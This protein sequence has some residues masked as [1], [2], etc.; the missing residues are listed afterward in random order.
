MNVETTLPNG[1]FTA[2]LTPLK[3]DLSVDY[4]ALIAH[5]NWLLDNGSDG[6]ALL[7]TTGE[8]NSFTMEERME[9][10]DKI[11]ESGISGNRLMAGT[12]CCAF[13]D[14]IRLTKFAVERGIGGILMLPPFYYKQ[15]NDK[16]LAKYFDL[17]ING[18]KDERLKIYLY[19]FPKMAGVGFSTPLIKHLVKE[20]P[21]KVVGMKD[22]TGDFEHMKEIINEFPGFKLYAGTEKYLLDILKIGGAGCISA[23]A[24]V[25]L[26]LTAKV[27]KTWK[28]GK[29]AAE[30][31][32]YLTQ[33]RMTF[34]GLPFT[35]ALKSLLGHLNY[36]DA[37]KH[38]RPPNTIV[39]VAEI[40]KLKEKHQALNFDF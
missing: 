22:S 29:N 11:I 37:W 32:S 2:N 3:E 33:V 16:G 38:V 17:I 27:Y 7:G 5:C 35:G 19:H 39:G 6:I 13:P 9:M 30:L 40:E 10:I 21:N 31:Q 14:T 12:G 4:P 18:V 24:N 28:E 23:T 8:A 25:T 1:V 34:E 15:V 36:G 20:Y 26:P